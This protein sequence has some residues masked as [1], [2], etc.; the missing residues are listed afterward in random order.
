MAPRTRKL[1]GARSAVTESDSD[2]EY[3]EKKRPKRARTTTQGQAQQDPSAASAQP[4]PSIVTDRPRRTIR[5]PRRYADDIEQAQPQRRTRT[6]R[7]A[8]RTAPPAGSAASPADS[9][10]EITPPANPIPP[11]TQ[12][13]YC[14]CDENSTHW[15]LLTVPC[16]GPH[17][18]PYFVCTVCIDR[19]NRNLGPVEDDAVRN[20]KVSICR[21]CANHER[22]RRDG[23][24]EGSPSECGCLCRIRYPTRCEAC[25]MNELAEVTKEARERREQSIRDGWREW[26][27]G[28]CGSQLQG[29]RGGTRCLACLGIELDP[30]DP[31]PEPE[32]WAQKLFHYPA[33][34]VNTDPP[35]FPDF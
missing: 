10:P 31:T 3:V 22:E 27:C 18:V 35:T 21:E 14:S 30:L 19:Q 34:W 6:R 23:T 32:D 11:P 25:R 15:M 4:Q 2:S 17:P 13:P 20:Q 24:L 29:R 28:M 26:L 7:G 12:N 1:P 8:A 5:L 33:D 16:S 9:E